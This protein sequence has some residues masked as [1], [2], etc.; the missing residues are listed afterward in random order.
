MGDLFS[1]T[2]ERLRTVLRLLSTLSLH[3]LAFFNVTSMVSFHTHDTWACWVASLEWLSVG[4]P[5]HSN[6][7]HCLRFIF[8]LTI[9]ERERERDG[10]QGWNCGL[11]SFCF[12]FNS[13]AGHLMCANQCSPPCLFLSHGGLSAFSQS[14]LT[15][16]KHFETYRNERNSEFGPRCSI[17]KSRFFTT[18]NGGLS[19]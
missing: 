9:R 14:G 16:S 7:H 18:R 4:H 15:R 5:T 17:C 19:V 13:V 10:G 1:Q 3:Q 8:F 2:L 11:C 6:L 12:R